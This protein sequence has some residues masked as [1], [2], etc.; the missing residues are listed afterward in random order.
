VLC[1]PS[2]SSSPPP[3]FYLSDMWRELCKLSLEEQ[4]LSTQCGC[5]L[6]LWHT[7]SRRVIIVII[8]LLHLTLRKSKLTPFLDCHYACFRLGSLASLSWFPILPWPLLTWSSLRVGHHKNLLICVDLSLLAPPPPMSYCSLVLST[9]GSLFWDQ[10]S[11]LT[12]SGTFWSERTRFGQYPLALYSFPSWEPFRTVHVYFT[13]H[14]FVSFE[15]DSIWYFS[16]VHSV[17][18]FYLWINFH[19]STILFGYWLTIA[20]YSDPGNV[21]QVFQFHKKVNIITTIP[22]Q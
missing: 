16:F 19:F 2:V 7:G 21:F 13:L 6:F 1:W 4:F 3:H 11:R 9:F 18:L 17:K 20:H 5:H 14:I 22:S 10:A 12:V 15:S 8:S